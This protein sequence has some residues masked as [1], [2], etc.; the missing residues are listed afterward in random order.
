MHN[1][2]VMACFQAAGGLAAG[3]SVKHTMVKECEVEAC[4]PAD[5]AETARP[6]STVRCVLFSQ[7]NAAAR[8]NSFCN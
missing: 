8:C 3:I 6:V 4:I 1:G 7:L 2:S 5:I